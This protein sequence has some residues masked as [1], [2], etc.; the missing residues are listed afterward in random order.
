MG[1]TL[2]KLKKIN[3]NRPKKKK[4][5]FLSDDLRLNSGI[6]TMS[7]ELV[8]GTADRYDWVQIG[9]AINHPDQ[10]K[11]FDISHDINK[12]LGIDHS[13]VKIYP[14]HGYGNPDM[15]RQIMD[16]EKPDAILHFTDPRFW[17]WL[18]EMEHE[19]RQHIPILY[20]NIWDD[21]PYPHWN[22]NAYESCDLIMSI[23]RQTYNINKQVCQ[24]KPRTDWD[25][26]YVPHGIDEKKCRPLDENDKNLNEIKEKLFGNKDYN[27]VLMYNSRNIRRKM[28][29]DLILAYRLFCDKLPAKQSKK[30]LLLLHTEASDENGTDLLAVIRALCPNYDV[31]FSEK[32]IDDDQLNILYNIADVGINI[33]SA[34]GFGLSCAEMMMAGNPV[35]VNCIGG[36]QDQIGIKNEEGEYLTKDDYTADWPSNSNGKYKDH[37]EWAFPV[38]PQI[39]LQG[40]V[41]TPYI[42]D[43]RCD[44]RDVS[45]KM[46][47]VYDLGR[48]ERKRIGKL[49]REFLINDSGMSAKG[50]CEAMYNSVEDTFKNWEPRKRFTLINTNRPKV[51][52]PDGIIFN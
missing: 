27:F 11:C 37:G 18:Y 25:L 40:S 33:S 28:T 14:T 34:E 47:E 12:E 22:E 36:L 48:K 35:I 39:N 17:Q 52:Y 3:P 38:W 46:R 29:S 2:P 31:K 19:I 44:I 10:G 5:L 8:V 24:R 41:P 50:M 9:G 45:K 13:S 1:I 42:Y 43:S 16:I 4:I 20:Y 32:K 51:E 30:C 15:L 7:K 21:L 6:G 26:T 49:G 23:S